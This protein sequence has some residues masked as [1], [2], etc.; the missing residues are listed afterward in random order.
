MAIVTKLLTAEE[1]WELPSPRWSELI[2]GVVVEMSPPGAEHGRK[3]VNVVRV[4][5][6]AEDRG[7]GYVLGEI[8]FVLRRNPDVVRAPDVAFVRK[9]RVPPTGIPKAFWEG[10][11]DLAVEVISPYDRPGE[12]QTKVREWIE[13]GA[14]QVWLLYADSRTVHVVRSLQDRVTLSADDLLEG[15]D[16]VP[17]FS[18]L[19]AELFD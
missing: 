19:V 14:R 8:G 10:A 15:G 17:G 11:P 7:V 18:F 4:L 2:D 12:I 16:A 1:F 5:L 3:Q 9:E 6:R 13:A